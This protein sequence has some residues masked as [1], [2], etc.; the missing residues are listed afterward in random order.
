MGV[1]KVRR[2]IP[3]A[4][5]LLY[6]GI[7]L[8]SIVLTLIFIWEADTIGAIILLSVDAAFIGVALIVFLS[9]YFSKPNYVEEEY[10]IYVWSSGSLYPE[11]PTGR[12]DLRRALD[13][14]VNK[15][16]VLI[17]AQ[18]P[19]TVPEQMITTGDLI[20]M[21]NQSCIEFSAK[22]LSMF[23]IGWSIKDAA[24]LQQGK[25]V[26]LHCQG[27]MVKSALYHELQHMVDE[28]ILHC[29][30]DYSH[31]RKDWWALTDKLKE[32]ATSTGVG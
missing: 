27:S 3:W 19:E 32:I 17:N 22:K 15:L 21:L 8:L 13:V 11:S 5:F 29:I 1:N 6:G 9:W 10:S 2:S 24:G 25:S 23:S 14:F 16:P 28:V 4:N 30:P 31:S 12:D 18:L 20:N 7:A 26:R